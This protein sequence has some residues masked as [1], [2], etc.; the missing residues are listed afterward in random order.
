MTPTSLVAKRD[1]VSLHPELNAGW[2][3]SGM[4]LEEARA[5]FAGEETQRFRANGVALTEVVAVR[6]FVAAGIDAD[7]ACAFARAALTVE[8]GL[9]Y[10]QRGL[11]RDWAEAG[12]KPRA[13]QEWAEGGFAPTPARGPAGLGVASHE[14]PRVGPY[15]AVGM[16]LS[17]GLST[18]DAV[19]LHKAGIGDNVARQYR[20]FGASVSLMLTVHG[21][22]LDC[23]WLGE[24]AREGVSLKRALESSV[25]VHALRAYCERHGKRCTVGDAEA[26]DR[27]GAQPGSDRAVR[28]RGNSKAVLEEAAQL[29]GVV[30]RSAE[31][32]ISRRGGETEIVG[33]Y[34][35]GSVH[36]VDCSDDGVLALYHSEGWGQYS[37]ACGAR[38]ASLA[39]L[40][41]HDDGH[42]FGVRV[43]G[44]IE[45][46][47]GGLA[48]PEPSDVR[49]TRE[50]RRR[51]LRQG[52]VDA[53]EVGDGHDR[54]TGD[55]RH[56]WHEEQ[57]EVRH[58][59]HGTFKVPF[60]ARLVS[61][62]RMGRG[63]GRGCGD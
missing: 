21:P 6:P 2:Y 32:E 4:A 43:L 60:P 5:G 63:R 15:L 13:A 8:G 17:V 39:Y 3:D 14:A 35:T 36:R 55:G 57:R 42:L 50:A 31:T 44:A 62:L 10:H 46:V 38:W 26:L 47:A 23:D 33:E 22:R 48:W 61:A 40:V 54:V 29:A 27:L 18:S 59:E 11:G 52:D 28:L 41:G 30:G 37:R 56:Q 45:G 25:D 19:R 53:A 16:D 34:R 1:A 24:F 58:A 7:A 9:A 51:V 20:E 12:I 49:K